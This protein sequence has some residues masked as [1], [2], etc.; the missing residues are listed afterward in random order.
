M[1]AVSRLGQY[2][3][4][5]GTLPGNYLAIT[6]PARDQSMGQKVTFRT[7]A[8]VTSFFGGLDVIDPGVVPVQAGI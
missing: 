5:T 1:G 2:G 8:E 4:G 6:H 7:Q 3:G